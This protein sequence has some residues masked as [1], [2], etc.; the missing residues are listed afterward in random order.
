MAGMVVCLYVTAATTAVFMQSANTVA[1]TA[2]IAFIYIFG[3]VF[4]FAFTS[5]QPIY[6]G[7]FLSNDMQAKG[8]GTF[9]LTD[10]VAGFVNISA[11]PY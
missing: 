8:I 2:A 6:P 10:G 1:S 7:E 9:K 11:A 3:L 5:M 4:A